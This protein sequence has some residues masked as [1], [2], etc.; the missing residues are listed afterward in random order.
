MRKYLFLLLF[1]FPILLWAQPAN[2]WTNTFN[3]EA[4]LLSGAVV[5]GNAEITAIFYNPAGISDVETSRIE[6][7]ASLFSIEHRKYEN[8]LGNNTKMDYWYF[9]FY[10]RFA[11]IYIHQ[12]KIHHSPINLLFLIETIPKR[13]FMIE[14]IKK[15]LN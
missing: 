14:Y 9:R 7:N 10:P 3:T 6:L 8:P 4:S 13:I 1:G 11:P 5:G 2:Y 15:T 12:R